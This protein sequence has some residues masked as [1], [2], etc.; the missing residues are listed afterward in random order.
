[1]TDMDRAVALYREAI[2]LSEERWCEGVYVPIGNPCFGS[3]LEPVGQ[4]GRDLMTEAANIGLPVAQYQ[5]GL[6][7]LFEDKH[8]REMDIDYEDILNIEQQRLSVIWLRNAA[9]QGHGEAALV[10]GDLYMNRVENVD[11]LLADDV[12]GFQAYQM[13]AEGDYETMCRLGE[14]YFLGKGTEKNYAAAFECFE[15]A[16]LA[17]LTAWYF[18]GECYMSGYGTQR[19]T[20]K[21]IECFL[22]AVNTVYKQGVFVKLG[23]IYMGI[24]G[25]EDIDLAKA[26]EYLQQVD[27]NKNPEAY[28]AAQELLELLNQQPQRKSGFFKPEEPA[29]RP[30]SDPQK[31]G[32]VSTKGIVLGAVIAVI[33]LILIIAAGGSGNSSHSD[34]NYN[35][36]SNYEEPD[37]PSNPVPVSNPYHHCYAV[38]GE[39]VLPASA[40]RNYEKSELAHLNKQELIIAR[41]EIYARHGYIFKNEDLAEY[42]EA[43]SW[44]SGT[45]SSSNFS[46]SVFNKYEKANIKTIVACEKNA[47]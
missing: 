42:F 8:R 24:N 37:I 43:C 30:Q 3:F 27:G 38:H 6:F 19:N 1:M 14:C 7:F 44:Y 2:T 5:L 31:T 28:R 34:G 11:F 41:N 32:G 25:D 47:G 46:D 35:H 29:D 36:P 39:S 22:K 18:L 45:V 33:A 15:K 9:K 20:A 16:K 23:C 10:L 12:R 26:R 13:G 4:K 17:S 21:A 40:S